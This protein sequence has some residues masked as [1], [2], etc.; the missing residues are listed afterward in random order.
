MVESS[1]LLHL[2]PHCANQT[3]LPEQV[4]Q[5]VLHVL[6]LARH[7]RRKGHLAGGAAAVDHFGAE[8]FGAP[9]AQEWRAAD[10]ARLVWSQG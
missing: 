1:G 6:R 8:L 5:H 2:L 3:F 7:G 10:G 4:P 9:R